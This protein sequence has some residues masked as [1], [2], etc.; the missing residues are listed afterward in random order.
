[1]KTGCFALLGHSIGALMAIKVA[2]RAR[3]E[4][5]VEPVLVVML[6][7]GAAQHPLFTE[8]GAQWLREEPAS[9]FEAWNPMVYK[10]YKL[11]GPVSE[12][13]SGVSRYFSR[14]A[15]D[16]GARTLEMW[17]KEQIM[18]Q[19]AG[20]SGASHSMP[21]RFPLR[22]GSKRA[23]DM[24]KREESAVPRTPSRSASIDSDVRS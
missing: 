2:K 20:R 16:L 6:E 4:L 5:G 15:G 19:A 12:A 24:A 13:F 18:D 10:L 14:S 22:I 8:K 11:P 1:M 21:C 17:A 3:R 23:K 9:F 7:R